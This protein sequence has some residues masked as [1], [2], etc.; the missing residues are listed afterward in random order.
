M[1]KLCCRASAAVSKKVEMTET[2]HALGWDI[3]PE[4]ECM[5]GRASIAVVVQQASSITASDIHVLGPRDLRDVRLVQK[6]EEVIEHDDC[7]V[8]GGGV[9]EPILF[10]MA[11]QVHNQSINR[12]SSILDYMEKKLSRGSE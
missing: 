6:L 7:Q 12:K 8:R 11:L 2:H 5:P 4:A 9:G 3:S 1:V 10:C